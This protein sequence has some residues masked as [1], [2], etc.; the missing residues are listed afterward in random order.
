MNPVEIISAKRDG[1]ELS[2]EEIKYFTDNFTSGQIPEYQMAAFL[3]AVYFNS[4]NANETAA[5]R[6]KYDNKLWIFTHGP[7]PAP[8]GGREIYISIPL[9]RLCSN[10]ATANPPAK[11]R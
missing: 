6:C 10:A 4:M 5:Q 8:D 2:P 7:E 9:G 3:M 1:R 11:R